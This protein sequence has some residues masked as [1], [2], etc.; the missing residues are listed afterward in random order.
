M[1]SR[2]KATSSSTKAK[3]SPLAVSRIAEKQPRLEHAAKL[4]TAL[5][6]RLS[7]ASWKVS[8]GCIQ[9]NIHEVENFYHS[10]FRA[11]AEQR[12]GLHQKGK[13]RHSLSYP[14]QH[15]APPSS[16]YVTGH[17][18]MVID[19]AALQAG[20]QTF[21][22]AGPFADAGKEDGPTYP[23]GDL[24]HA[25]IAEI[26]PQYRI[27]EVQ[28]Q[29]TPP[30]PPPS[31]SMYNY[32]VSPLVG[33][34]STF[35]PVANGPAG[36][37]VERPPSSLQHSYGTANGYGDFWQ[38]AASGAD[39][40]GPQYANYQ[41]NSQAAM[42]MGGHQPRESTFAA[43]NPPPS[44]PGHS[45]LPPAGISNSKPQ[46]INLNPGHDRRFSL[47]GSGDIAPSYPSQEGFYT[48]GD[49][50]H[51]LPFGSPLRRHH[52]QK[53]NSQSLRGEFSASN[54]TMADLDDFGFASR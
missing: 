27:P 5:A 11:Q 15:T 51:G 19:E 48:G 13:S 20:Q 12:E 36:R 10:R 14:A 46:P 9:N 6:T 38:G 35:S 29:P 41:Q 7:Y 8:H 31:P 53:S 23:F 22:S 33:S 40:A 24:S 45:L 26:E 49:Y 17:G 50:G 43:P 42:M 2:S 32:L 54:V 30:L 16:Y 52:H 34:K 37:H 39:V 1:P 21:T 18:E 4:A 44:A 25:P 3:K 47:T 28:R